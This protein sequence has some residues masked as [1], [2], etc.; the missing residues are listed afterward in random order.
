MGNRRNHPDGAPVIFRRPKRTVCPCGLKG[1]VVLNPPRDAAMALARAVKPAA[2]HYHHAA[3]WRHL[4][5]D[6]PFR[7]DPWAVAYMVDGVAEAMVTAV[8]VPTTK[9]PGALLAAWM[10][11]PECH[12]AL[13]GGLVMQPYLGRQ[14]L[15]LLAYDPSEEGRA[16][17]ERA[18]WARFDAREWGGNLPRPATRDPNPVTVDPDAA[19]TA[20]RRRFSWSIERGEDERGEC[21]WHWRYAPGSSLSPGKFVW[22]RSGVCVATTV[23][24]QTFRIED[25]IFGEAGARDLPA[26]LAESVC[27]ASSARRMVL[28]TNLADVEAA[29]RALGLKP[30]R[31]VPLYWRGADPKGTCYRSLAD[32]DFGVRVWW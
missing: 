6:N 11:L 10:R 7:V 19:W 5:D 24:R 30:G 16:F 17:Y 9:G 27:H 4:Y 28:E 12:S 2:R 31:L 18:G 25:V 15:Q 26:A 8:G 22:R 20:M 32:A 3:Y 21:L 1:E 29:A 23:E 13:A 14:D